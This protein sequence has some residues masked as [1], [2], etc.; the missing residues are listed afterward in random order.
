MKPRILIGCE[1]S[2]T[3]KRA[4]HCRVGMHGHVMYC[5]T[6]MVT[7]SSTCSV[8]YMMQCGVDIGT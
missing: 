5:L 6:M 8:M 4:L 2:G 3:M 7:L 1:T